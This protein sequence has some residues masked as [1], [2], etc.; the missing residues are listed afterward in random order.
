MEN[1]ISVQIQ[2]YLNMFFFQT[3]EDLNTSLK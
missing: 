3:N 1:N 2:L